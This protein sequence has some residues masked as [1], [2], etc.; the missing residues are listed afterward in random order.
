MELSQ[1]I[2]A[3]ILS[4]CDIDKLLQLKKF[5]PKLVKQELKLRIFS[6]IRWK[7]E[8][9]PGNKFEYNQYNR[10]YLKYYQYNCDNF[11]FSM[12]FCPTYYETEVKRQNNLKSSFIHC[13]YNTDSIFYSSNDAEGIISFNFNKDS[14]NFIGSIDHSEYHYHD[15]A[16][17]YKTR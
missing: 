7:F 5:Y 13:C 9:K 8:L 2:L 14:Q 11:E 1:Y 12:K 17:I 6:K 15:G 3:L 16:I 10:N 4:Y